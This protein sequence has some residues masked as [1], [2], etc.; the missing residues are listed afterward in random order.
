MLTATIA[1][2]ASSPGLESCAE[3]FIHSGRQDS[4]D[5]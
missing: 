4:Y 2:A 3:S 1:F 5:V